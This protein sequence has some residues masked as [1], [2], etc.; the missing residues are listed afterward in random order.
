MDPPGSRSTNGLWILL[1]VVVQWSMDP[2]GS[3][4]TM[5]YGS[6]WQSQYNGL[7]ILLAVVVQ[8]SLDP[9]SSRSAMVYGSFYDWEKEGMPTKEVDIKKKKRGI[10]G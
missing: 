6:S 7:W 3:R 10:Y 1:A 2:P 8:W 5:V 9:P 4:S